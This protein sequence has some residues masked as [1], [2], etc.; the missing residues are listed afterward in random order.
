MLYE[1]VGHLELRRA[2]DE[3]LV[4]DLANEKI[5]V[6]NQTAGDLLEYCTR[7]SSDDLVSFLRSRYEINGQDID[8]DVREI[9]ERFVEDG[10]VTVKS[11]R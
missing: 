9:M 4:H 6:L 1:R 8:R 10:L 3:M 7:A 11:G 5:H 2:G